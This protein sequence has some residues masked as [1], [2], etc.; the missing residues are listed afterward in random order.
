MYTVYILFSQKLDRFYVG[1]TSDIQ[2][3][4]EE[5]NRKKGKYTDTGI[6]WIVMYTEEYASKKDAMSREKFI[7]AKKSRAFIENLVSSDGSAFRLSGRVF[8][9]SGTES[10]ENC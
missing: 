2:R 9:I 3:R 4:L 6:P 8:R 1:Y 10:P 7:K 5:H